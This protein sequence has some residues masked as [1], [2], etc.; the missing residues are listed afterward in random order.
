MSLPTRQ[1]TCAA[2]GTPIQDADRWTAELIVDDLTR[3]VAV[4]DGHSCYPRK[5]DERNES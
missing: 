2:C 4:H 1:H 3:F 5:T